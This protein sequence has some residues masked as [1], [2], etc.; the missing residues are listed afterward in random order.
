MPSQ[1]MELS[2]LCLHDGEILQRQ[3]QQQPVSNGCFDDRP[4]SPRFGPVWYGI[5][6]LGVRL[7]DELVTLFYFLC[8]HMAE[9]PAAEDWPFCKKREHWLYDEIHWHGG[10][11]FT[12][13]ILLSS[14]AVLTIPFATGLISRFSLSGESQDR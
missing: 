11:S 8:D 10:G 3:E 13:L 5:A 2:K 12:H 14:G 1:V 4:G 6:T 7:D 9:Q